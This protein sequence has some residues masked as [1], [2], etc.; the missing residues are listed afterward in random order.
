MTS[1]TTTLSPPAKRQRTTLKESTIEALQQKR[2]P[3]PI[4]IISTFISRTNKT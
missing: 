3:P 2:A 4:K 1:L